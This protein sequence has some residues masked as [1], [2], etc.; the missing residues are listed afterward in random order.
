MVE[1]TN[2]VSHRPTV[3]IIVPA[4]NEAASL[5][6]FVTSLRVAMR[7]GAAGADWHVLFVDDGSKD[8]TWATIRALSAESLDFG[9]L[10]FSRNF[11]KEAAIEAGLEACR[12]HD[13]CIVIDADL[14]HPPSL[15]PVLIATW[16]A[17]GVAIVSAVKEDRQDEGLL[18]GLVARVFYR[19]FHTAAGLDLAHASDFKLV[20]RRVVDAYLALP[21]RGK[22]FRGL[23]R[24]LGFAESIVPFR[25]APRTDGT[26]SRWS[27][28]GLLRYGWAAVL[29]FSGVPLRLVRYL[30]I[31]MMIFA[32]LLGLQ[33][34]AQKLSGH[35][36]E[37]FTT[38]ILL[39]LLIGSAILFAL[40]IIG[41]YMERIYIEAKRRPNYVVGEYVGQ[42]WIATQ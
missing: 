14:Q 30:A 34:L 4:Y 3:A 26:G 20:N 6:T 13:A 31:G 24:W 22:F 33:T 7:D 10:R 21:E 42:D 28:R 38:V 18:R 27:V 2:R 29:S 11:G 35:A 15:I 25:V 5:N 16:Q 19:L 9:G 1:K 37:G 41:D 36:V 12:G 8:E 39:M 17:D 40:G 32:L 23:T